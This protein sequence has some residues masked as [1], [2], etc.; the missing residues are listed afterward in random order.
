MLAGNLVGAPAIIWSP[1][2]IPPL[3]IRCPSFSEGVN[4]LG[5]KLPRPSEEELEFRSW[6]IH[7]PLAWARRWPASNALPKAVGQKPF[8]LEQFSEGCS[9]RSGE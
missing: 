7:G 2:T 3:G 1:L 8:Q 5:H 9:K 6:P 4:R